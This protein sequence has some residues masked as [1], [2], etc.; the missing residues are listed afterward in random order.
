MLGIRCISTTHTS[1]YNYDGEWSSMH[2]FDSFTVRVSAIT[3][4]LRYAA[5]LKL[6]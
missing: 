2:S 1:Y 4:R 5:W 3:H 6:C